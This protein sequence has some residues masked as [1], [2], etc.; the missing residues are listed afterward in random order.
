MQMSRICS[1]RHNDGA[2][3]VVDCRCPKAATHW[4]WVAGVADPKMVGKFAGCCASAVS[5]HAAA[6]PRAPIG[7]SPPTS[8]PAPQVA[9]TEARCHSDRDG[10]QSMAVLQHQGRPPPRHDG[11][12]KS[13]HHDGRLRMARF[14]QPSPSYC[15]SDSSRHGRLSVRSA[16]TIAIPCGCGSRQKETW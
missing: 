5:G 11:G 3:V 8:G 10:C 12:N 15:R 14:P 7:S 13:R 4:P 9:E 16:I 6:P 2:R 1:A